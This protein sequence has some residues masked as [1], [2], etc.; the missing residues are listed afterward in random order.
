LKGKD[1][2]HYIAG[3]WREG[4]GRAFESTQPATG[5]VLWK[6]YCAEPSDIEAAVQAAQFAQLGWGALD[7]FARVHY[8]KTFKNVLT[9]RAEEMAVAIATETGKPLWDAKTEVQTMLSKI[10]I[11]VQSYHDRTG[12]KNETVSGVQVM[13]R[14]RPHG[15]MLILGPFNFPGHLPNGHIVPA[16]LAGNTVILKPSEQTPKVAELLVQLWEAAG[17]PKGVLNLLQGDAKTAQ[18]LVTH[19]GIQGVLFTGSYKAGRSIHEQLAGHPEKIVALE[20]GGNNPLIVDEVSDIKA[21]VLNIIQSAYVNAGQRCTCARRM[22]VVK[23]RNHEALMGALMGAIVQISVGLPLAQPQ[24][25]MGS[26]ISKAAGDAV[27]AA[28]AALIQKG[29]RPLIEVRKIGGNSALLSPGLI[30]MTGI[31]PDDN[32]IFGPLLQVITVDTLDEAI[33]EANR[34]QY[35]LSASILT[36]SKESFERFYDRARAGIVNWN[37][38]TTGASYAAPFG[39]IGH[40]GNFRPTAY[41]AADYCAYPVVSTISSTLTLAGKL[42]N[43][44]VL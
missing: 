33:A 19:P 10:D 31:Q 27:L 34:T 12:D 1:M 43:G 36:D 26:V 17:L 41:Y 32:E 15:V 21:A 25:Y 13:T 4:E 29:A 28:Q 14:H 18:A 24:P 2:S 16:I 37:K 35:G 5:E 20:M 7:L 38:P 39:G 9:E 8:L 30:D 22:I 23:H 42:P 44:I 6:G 11:S 3:E 40:S